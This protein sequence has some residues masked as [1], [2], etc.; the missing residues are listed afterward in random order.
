MLIAAVVGGATMRTGQPGYGN[1][2][3]RDEDG[4]TCE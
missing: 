4:K 1:H 3:E 2:L